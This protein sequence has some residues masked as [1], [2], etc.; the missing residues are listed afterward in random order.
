MKLLSVVNV[1]CR[2]QWNDDDRRAKM[3]KEAALNE[4][5]RFHNTSRRM[6][7]DR[8]RWPKDGE[9]LIRS[10]GQSHAVGSDQVPSRR[11]SLKLG[12]S[13]RVHNAA[14]KTRLAVCLGSGAVTRYVSSLAAL[15]TDLAGRV[16]R[17]SIG[18]GTI[19]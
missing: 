15:V 16:E 13:S 14:V 18:S 17:T 1:K 4:G 7:D 9:G 12:N 5:E 19:A 2:H 8:E 6:G 10:S 11:C 3:L